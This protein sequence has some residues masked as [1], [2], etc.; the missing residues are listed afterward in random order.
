M[1]KFST[2]I[3]LAGCA[4]QSGE[5]T[6]LQL[7]AALGGESLDVE[8]P[9]ISIDSPMPGEWSSE[10]TVTVTGQAFDIA[11]G[12][13]SATINGI[14]LPLDGSGRGRS[15]E[16][17]VT[18]STGVNTIVLTATDI[19]GNTTEKVISVMG[20]AFQASDES[21]PSASI[22]EL[23][24][25]MME[26]IAEPI[27]NSFSNRE[28]VQGGVEASTWSDCAV[29]EGTIS[30]IS[31]G[32]ATGTVT[33]SEDGMEITADFATVTAEYSG[34]ADICGVEEPFTVTLSHTAGS[35]TAQV[36]LSAEEGAVAAETGE[37]SADLSGATI[38]SDVEEYLADHDIALA[39]M[40]FET[41]FAEAMA[42]MLDSTPEQA[43]PNA[44]DSITPSKQGFEAIGNASVTYTMDDVF[45]DEDGIALSYEASIEPD[46]NAVNT[47]RGA[48]I[49]DNG[50]MSR[51]SAA[52]VNS[53][54]SV[55][56][57]NRIIHAGWESGAIT[58]FVDAEDKGLT[59]QTWPT[60]P[61]V[62]TRG[63]TQTIKMGELHVEVRN[64]KSL[65]A[66]INVQAEAEIS[67]E[68]DENDKP[69]MVATVTDVYS[70]NLTGN[71]PGA[72]SAEI[73]AAIQAT[74]DAAMPRF[75]AP[76]TPSMEL[77][78]TDS[79][80]AGKKNGW[81]AHSY[82]ATPW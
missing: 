38:S 68:V 33:P 6:E 19:A 82:D 46:E 64:D 29:F 30:S 40:D 5:T 44:I 2:F 24:G 8:A 41:M 26:A 1:K 52:A 55:H 66:R 76:F 62:I 49:T 16:A 32:D 78:H 18:L 54:S 22:V 34:T 25:P 73:D 60:M 58:A 59:V 12:I 50:R 77:E 23:N 21:I 53:S 4:T 75:E 48:V 3:F 39:D 51:N 35:Y 43:V 42:G 47:S 17:P 7:Q 13:A 56:L 79:D 31:L 61:P 74:F 63:E 20:N 45:S 28:L 14:A 10:E 70:A 57:L 81:V 71:A 72:M 11:S 9:I 65:V 67:F 15:F 69:V 37:S 36:G 27:G 80:S